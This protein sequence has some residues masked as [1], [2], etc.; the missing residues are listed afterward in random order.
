MLGSFQAKIKKVVLTQL[1]QGVS[2]E[3]LALSCALA[4]VLGTFPVV[5]ATTVLIFFMAVYLRLNQPI[6]QM[7]NYALTPV[8]LLLLPVFLRLG[9]WVLGVPPISFNP[10][11][12]MSELKADPSLFFSNYGMAALH[13]SLA[14][15]LTAPLVGVILFLVLKPLFKRIQRHSVL[16]DTKKGGS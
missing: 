4:F 2:P 10:S 9:E 5:G 1:T 16:R 11:V 6:M 15:L 8:H 12:M 13:A 7:L 14:W 3:S